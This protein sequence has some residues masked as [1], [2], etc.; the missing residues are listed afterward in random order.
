MR[1]Y[2]LAAERFPIGFD[3]PATAAV[4]S[5]SIGGILSIDTAF[6]DR[7]ESIKRRSIVFQ[8]TETTRQI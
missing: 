6:V 5:S 2:T 1:H 7:M 3:E 8:N 4:D